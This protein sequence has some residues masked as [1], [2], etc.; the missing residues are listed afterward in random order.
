MCWTLNAGIG[1]L[2]YNAGIGILDSLIAILYGY[3][4]AVSKALL[5]EG[6]YILW[7]HGNHMLVGYLISSVDICIY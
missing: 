4:L 1:V 6:V 7:G 3:I 5:T 2:D